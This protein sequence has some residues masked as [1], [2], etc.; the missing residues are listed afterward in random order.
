M[1]IIDCKVVFFLLIRYDICEHI[2]KLYPNIY[3]IIARGCGRL[4]AVLFLATSFFTL[5]Y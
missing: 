3:D 4:I 1:P 2:I 5:E